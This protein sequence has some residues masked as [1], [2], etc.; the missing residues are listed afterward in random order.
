M[1]SLHCSQTL[2]KLPTPLRARAESWQWLTRPLGFVRHLLWPLLRPLLP[3]PFAHA[4][5]TLASLVLLE[6][7]TVPWTSMAPASSAATF[8]PTCAWLTPS[9]PSIC[10]SHLHVSVKPVPMTVCFSCLPGL[11]FLILLTCSLDCFSRQHLLTVA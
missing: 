9:W 10:S 6:H 7:G 11:S 5:A 1:V 2:P 3:P 4:L 8:F